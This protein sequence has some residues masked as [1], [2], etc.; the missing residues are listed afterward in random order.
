MPATSNA[1]QSNQTVGS[2]NDHDREFGFCFRFHSATAGCID[3]LAFTL[4]IAVCVL[5]VWCGRMN[6]VECVRTTF[7]NGILLLSI[8][9][10]REPP[11]WPLSMMNLVSNTV[12]LR[13]RIRSIESANCMQWRSLGYLSM[14]AGITLVT[15]NRVIDCHYGIMYQ[16][17][18]NWRL[19]LGDESLSRSRFDL[20]SRPL[21][22]AIDYF[23]YRLISSTGH[24]HR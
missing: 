16:A 14:R 6:R 2:T 18:C 24:L 1:T 21:R 12:S 11:L 19:A 17:H 4:S 10:V 22:E 20:G 15:F 3:A 8:I 5:S 13:L 7:E 9:R 23:P